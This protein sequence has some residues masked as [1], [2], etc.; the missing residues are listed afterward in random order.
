MRHPVYAWIEQIGDTNWIYSVSNENINLTKSSQSFIVFIVASQ[1]HK[2]MLLHDKINLW[3]APTKCKF[4]I[5]KATFP[6]WLICV[7]DD[8]HLDGWSRLGFFVTLNRSEVQ[9][10]WFEK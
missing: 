9:F 4:V 3:V 10:I 7:F 1:K 2:M 6:Q 5:C 8:K